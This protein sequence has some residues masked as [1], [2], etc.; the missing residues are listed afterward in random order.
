MN[1]TDVLYYTRTL[2]QSDNP[3]DVSEEGTTLM[4][5][6]KRSHNKQYMIDKA[7]SPDVT[8]GSPCRFS[9]STVILV[10]SL[11]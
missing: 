7:I 10:S 2:H 1:I 11:L 6:V 8:E 4:F 9:I 5:R 3:L